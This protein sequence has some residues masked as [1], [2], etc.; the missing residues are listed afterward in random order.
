MTVQAS[1]RLVFQ[2]VCRIGGRQGYY[3]ANWLWRVRG[4]I[5]RIVG[6]PGLHRGRRDENHVAFADAIDFWRVSR[7]EPEGRLQLRAEMR[8]PGEGLLEFEVSGPDPA[9]DTSLLTQTVVFK[10][11]GWAGMA[12]WQGILPLHDVVFGGMIDGIRRAAEGNATS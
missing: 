10:P 12:Y 8:L 7:F 4:W 11:R 6:G 3:A 1:P 2:T 9:G 5:D